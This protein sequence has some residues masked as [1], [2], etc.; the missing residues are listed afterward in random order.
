MPEFE[1]NKLDYYTVQLV[2]KTLGFDKDQYGNT[3]FSVVFQGDATTFLWLAKNKPEVGKKYYGHLETTKSGKAVRFKTDKVPDNEPAPA[4]AAQNFESVD[5]RSSIY[6][7]VALNDAAIVFQG[8]GAE[9]A[10]VLNLAEKFNDW[11]NEKSVDVSVVNK[12]FPEDL[13]EQERY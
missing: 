10:D 4:Q 9:T 2:E 13:D 6:R 7:S 3:W 11:L 12:I 1:L 5:K 8:T